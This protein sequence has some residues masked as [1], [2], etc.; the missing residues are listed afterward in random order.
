MTDLFT[1]LFFPAAFVVFALS[2]YLA[3]N[4]TR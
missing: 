3:L 2:A 4:R 1:L